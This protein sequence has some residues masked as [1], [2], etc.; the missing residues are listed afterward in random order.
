MRFGS[1]V[2]SGNSLA[3]KARGRVTLTSFP[4]TQELRRPMPISCGNVTVIRERPCPRW[5]FICPNTTQV[6]AI[7]VLDWGG[8]IIQ[9]PESEVKLQP[10]SNFLG[11]ELISHNPLFKGQLADLPPLGT[12]N[13]KIV[14]LDADSAGFRHDFLAVRVHLVEPN[15]EH[16]IPTPMDVGPRIVH[17]EKRVTP[18][19]AVEVFQEKPPT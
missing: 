12:N 14:Q 5:T 7:C 3:S 2:R 17:I 4:R 6:S 10:T 18:W 13:G 1:G 16:E 15:K 11:V 19:I 9:P 8:R